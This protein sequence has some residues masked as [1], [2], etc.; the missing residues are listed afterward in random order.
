[1]KARVLLV[2]DHPVLQVELTEMLGTLFEV[3]AVRATAADA[4]AWLRAN[5]DGWDVA[6]VDI[7]LRQGHGF[8]VLRQCGGRRDGQSVVMLSNY[9]REP[10]RSSALNL[11]ADAVFDKGFE[12]EGFWSWCEQ[13][14]GKVASTA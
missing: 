8:D 6:V 12:M 14:A 2:E 3:A 4:I 9:T 13:R 11:G 5:P 1:M 7:F 10:A